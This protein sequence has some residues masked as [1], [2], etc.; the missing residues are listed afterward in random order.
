MHLLWIAAVLAVT[1]L[2]GWRLHRA[3]SRGGERTPAASDETEQ[4][5]RRTLL[6]RLRG[7]VQALVWFYGLWGA[8][9]LAAQSGRLPG[10]AAELLVEFLRA[11]APAGLA[12][13]AFWGAYRAGCAAEVVLQRVAA[14]T[15]RRFDDII[16]GVLGTALRLAV[17]LL[18]LILLLRVVDLPAGVA[19]FTA[20][21]AS[22]AL[23]L[24][25]AWLARRAILLVD[26][27][28]LGKATPKTPADRALFTRVRV[29]RKI[30]LAFVVV[31]TISAVLMSFE[32]VRDVGRSLLAS[33]GLAGIVIGFAA[34]RSLGNLFAGLQIALTQPIRLDDLVLVEGDVGNIEEIT[35]TYVVVR[36]WD[37]RRIVL[38]ISY[39]IERP[40]Q[41]WTRVP[42][43]MLS[44]LALR[45]DFSLPLDALR[46]HLKQEIEKSAFWDKQVFG[47]QVTNSDATSM[48][49]RVLASAPDPGASFNLQCELREKAID[50]V[51]R[52]FPS[53]LPK[54]RREQLPL[55]SWRQ[56]A[57]AGEE[58]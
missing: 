26:D 13:A 3:L 42:T 1:A 27:A 45:F 21:A 44:P 53:A 7:P 50:F 37:Q 39:F 17:P 34:Q 2:V 41:N 6:R 47:V 14:R 15:E 8:L 16:L 48:E 4:T 25:V 56:S 29:L 43:N 51:R 54:L 24:A 38:P 9:W 28:V 57:L 46:A 30:A 33:A 5:L 49:V 36:V 58:R 40:F 31:F 10:G 55:E 12:V 20:K 19:A 32:E 35:L 11:L 23:I 22:I 52:N 18:G